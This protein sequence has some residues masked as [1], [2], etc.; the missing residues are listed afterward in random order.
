MKTETLNYSAGNLPCKG[1]LAYDDKAHGKKPVVIIAHTWEG[2]TPFCEERA[3]E[4]VNLGYVAFAVDLYGHGKQSA[5]S[6]EAEA[7][8]SPLFMDRALLRERI[9][10]AYNT[11]KSLPMADDKKMGA[12]GFCFGGLT[13]IELLKSGVDLR[14]VVS[15]HGVLGDKMGPMHAKAVQPASKLHGSLLVLHGIKDPLVPIGDV[16]HLQNEMTRLNV[17]WQTNIYSTAGHGF[18]NPDAHDKSTGLYFDPLANARSMQSM[19][20]FFKERFA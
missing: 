20:D 3:K 7:L 1:Y 5:N 12:I 10:A 4:I 11:A 13:V 17:E 6:E 14:G 16:I 2:L 15:F 18:T 8:M 9:V 19:R